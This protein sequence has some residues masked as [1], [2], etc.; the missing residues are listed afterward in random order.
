MENWCS[1]L[2]AHKIIFIGLVT[3]FVLVVSRCL[4]MILICRYRVL[5]V[6]VIYSNIRYFVCSSHIRLFKFLFFMSWF[7]TWIC[8]FVKQR[9]N[10]MNCYVCFRMSPYS[11]YHTRLDWIV[12]GAFECGRWGS[13]SNSDVVDCVFV[14]SVSTGY[15]YVYILYVYIPVV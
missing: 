1:Y 9:N 12:Q 8:H 15:I 10:C 14:A 6:S 7:F 5:S 4:F 11:R 2:I 13:I 3:S